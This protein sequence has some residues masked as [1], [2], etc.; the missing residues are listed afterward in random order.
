MSMNTI[1]ATCFSRQTNVNHNDG[2]RNES[3]SVSSNNRQVLKLAPWWP[4]FIAFEIFRNLGSNYKRLNYNYERPKYSHF[5][6]NICLLIR[7]PSFRKFYE[8]FMKVL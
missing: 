5:L 7:C 1:L 2:S 6:R 4:K 3:E 8:S